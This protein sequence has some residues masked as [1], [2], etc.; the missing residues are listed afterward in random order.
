MLAS[1]V[2]DCSAF[3]ALLLTVSLN[4]WSRLL[5]TPVATMAI[6][7]HSYAGQL[8]YDPVK[9]FAPVA[10]LSNFQV[11]LGVAANV[12]AKTL[13]EYVAWVKSD[14]A[15][16]GFYASAASGSIACCAIRRGVSGPSATNR[17]AS[18]RAAAADR[19][20]VLADVRAPNVAQGGRG[21]G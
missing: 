7:P 6:F 4:C 8:R 9:D 20:A 3:A 5:M 14:P 10:H 18:T 21:T 12:P 1:W 17:T 19:T 11:G 2:R 13:A 15:K 16:N